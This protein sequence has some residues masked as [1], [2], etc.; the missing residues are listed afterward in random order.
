MNLS[1]S[2]RLE[3]FLDV[4][5]FL[6]IFVSVQTVVEGG[7][8]TS[9]EAATDGHFQCLESCDDG[10]LY[11]GYLG[12]LTP[13]GTINARY[14]LSYFP[15]NMECSMVPFD[16]EKMLTCDGE[17]TPSS[18][19]HWVIIFGGSNAFFAVKNM[20]DTLLELPAS[21]YFDPAMQYDAT[22]IGAQEIG[23]VYDFI[24]DQD[25]N[26]IHDGYFPM[27]DHVYWYIPNNAA[28]LFLDVPVP[29]TGGT[30]VSFMATHYASDFQWFMN[31]TMA[32]GSPWLTTKPGIDVHLEYSAIWG[33]IDPQY[34]QTWYYP[35]GVAGHV[36]NIEYLNARAV[37]EDINVRSF[38][39]TDSAFDCGNF[40]YSASP[41]MQ[42]AVQ[43]TK[44]STVFPVRFWS[45][46][47]M[48]SQQLEISGFCMTDW[49][50]FPGIQHVMTIRYWNSICM[51]SSADDKPP[52]DSCFDIPPVEYCFWTG[53]Y[54]DFDQVCTYEFHP[55]ALPSNAGYCPTDIPPESL[56]HLPIC[57]V[58]DAVKISR[59]GEV[60]FFNTST[61]ILTGNTRIF[62]LNSF[63]HR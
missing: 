28:Q 29:A 3:S 63:E 38:T 22:G 20:I 34:P 41:Q 13:A 57:T 1:Q 35:G 2:L 36:Q 26:L 61:T 54:W 42:Q 16:R 11:S 58:L 39:M 23:A 10:H 53:A 6:Y 15:N 32:P 40:D 30:R 31:L 17:V 62:Y 5:I 18:P 49:H 4:I 59:I 9:D 47:T 55:S 19:N 21:T 60:Y 56:V 24:W 12:P 43:E 52:L 46:H 7:Y 44:D 51:H 50:A 27:Q 48:L 37:N 25:H 8:C 45:K 33:D 14:C